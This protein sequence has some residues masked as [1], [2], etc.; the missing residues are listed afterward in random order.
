M[1]ITREAKEAFV[2]R[3]SLVHRGRN[4]NYELRY[5][6]IAVERTDVNHVQ[7]TFLGGTLPLHRTEVRL[8]V[9]D[10][11]YLDGS[12]GALNGQL[13]LRIECHDQALRG[14]LGDCYPC[15]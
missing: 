9:G 5:D 2:E 6:R 14:S 4:G 1:P 3:S 8:D 10:T 7:V 12:N 13:P 15:V 11:L